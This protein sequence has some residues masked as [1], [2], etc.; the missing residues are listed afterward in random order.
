MKVG[1]LGLLNISFS[2]VY[3]GG[4]FD[5]LFSVL[6]IEEMFRVFV[7]LLGIFMYLDIVGLYIEWYGLEIL[8]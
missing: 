2:E 7:D 6:L 5:F 4:G 1:E 8:K 3:G